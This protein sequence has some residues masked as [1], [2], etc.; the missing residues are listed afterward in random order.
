MYTVKRAAEIVG[1]STSTLRAWERRY[2]TEATTRSDAGYRLYDEQA[3][4]RFVLLKALIDDGLSAREAAEE[5][6]RRDATGVLAPSGPLPDNLELARAAER[7]DPAEVERAL[8][9]RLAASPFEAVVDQWLLPSL[10]ELGDAWKS[11]EVSV[12][13]EHMVAEAVRRVLAAEY[14]YPRPAAAG[15]PVLIGLPPGARHDLGLLSFAV[16][17]RRAGIPTTYLGADVPA[18]SWQTAVA[19]GCSAVVMAVSRKPD[20]KNFER[21]HSELRAGRRRLKIAVGGALQAETPADCLQLGHEVG[22]AALAL[23]RELGLPDA[24]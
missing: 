21:V 19:G 8:R 15:R 13:G 1:V 6:R 12:A 20:L 2:G 11:G 22:P 5:I 14:E 7:L 23:S 16:A 24:A 10:V 9:L 3:V 17:A 4:R 18:E